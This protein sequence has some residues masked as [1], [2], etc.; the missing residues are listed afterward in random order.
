MNGSQKRKVSLLVVVAAFMVFSPWVVSFILF[1]NS[2]L[3]QPGGKPLFNLT[4][5]IAV[6][7]WVQTLVAWITLV[8][9]AIAA[10]QIFYL[11]QQTALAQEQAEREAYRPLISPSMISAKRL[12]NSQEIQNELTKLD[13]QVSAA[14]N[15]SSARFEQLLD[16]TRKRFDEIAKSM[17]WPLLN[18]T[19]ASLDHVEMLINEYNYL[20]KLIN[21]KRLQEKFATDLGVENFKRVYDRVGPLIRL[22]R[23]LSPKYA[24]HFKEYCQK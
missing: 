15:E 5:F 18:G 1:R 10:I 7:L 2:A 3:A 16:T 13:A 23:H 12:L 11:Q 20:S 24:S 22:R 9:L 21:A 17:S 14:V 4:D 8:V 19:Y 6:A